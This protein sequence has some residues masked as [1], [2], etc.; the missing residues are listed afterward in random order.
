MGTA[1][2]VATLS[3]ALA[4]TLPAALDDAGLTDPAADSLASATRDSAGTTIPQL[5]AQGEH[6]PLREH[7]GAAVDALTAGFA[8]ATRWALLIAAVFLLLG[9]IGALR[10]PR[11][12]GNH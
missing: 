3:I 4:A 12:S 6:G 9:F 5:R 2:A 1:F 11:A 7:T 8:D 10:L